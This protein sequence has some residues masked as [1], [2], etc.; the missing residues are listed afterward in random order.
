ML[1]QYHKAALISTRDFWRLLLRENI[2]LRLLTKAFRRIDLMEM[3]AD[4]TYKIVLERWVGGGGR[5]WP[6]LKG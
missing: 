2:N 6:H 3:M 5:L 4:K 1:Q